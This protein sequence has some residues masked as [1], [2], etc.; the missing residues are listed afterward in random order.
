MG[1]VQLQ[2]AAFPNL[3]QAWHRL[4]NRL[5]AAVRIFFTWR[6]GWA[7]PA[8]PTVTTFAGGCS[9]DFD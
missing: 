3:L 9:P 4:E 5:S 1:D 2:V 6:A 7:R 8:L